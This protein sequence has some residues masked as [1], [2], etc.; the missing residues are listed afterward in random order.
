QRFE[1]AE[2][3][4]QHHIRAAPTT[5]HNGEILHELLRSLRCSLGEGLSGT[6]PMR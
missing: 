2:D 6:E 4:K 5:H 3:H 1:W